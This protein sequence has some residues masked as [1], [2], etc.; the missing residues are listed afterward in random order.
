MHMV[1]AKPKRLAI[2]KG[3][4]DT[5]LPKILWVSGLIWDGEG[6]PKHILRHATGPPGPSAAPGAPSEPPPLCLDSC[7][8]GAG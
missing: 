8:E 1:G 2:Y 6:P 5:F 3:S 7:C 4:F